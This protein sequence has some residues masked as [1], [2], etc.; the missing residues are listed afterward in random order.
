[1]MAT[2]VPGRGPGRN[3]KRRRGERGA[4]RLGKEAGEGGTRHWDKEGRGKGKERRGRVKREEWL[5]ARKD[6]G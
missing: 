3:S 1:L 4:E 5:L 6:Q 2:V